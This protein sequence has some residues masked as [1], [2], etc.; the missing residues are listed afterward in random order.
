MR[1]RTARERRWL[2]GD[3]ALLEERKGGKEREGEGNN[4]HLPFFTFALGG[5]LASAPC[6]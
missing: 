2:F 4:L 1:G 3:P 6:P 5:A